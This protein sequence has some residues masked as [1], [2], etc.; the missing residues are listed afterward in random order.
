RSSARVRAAAV[1]RRLG[2]TDEARA[3]LQAVLDDA[4]A[5]SVAGARDA[6]SDALRA[7]GDPGPAP[8]PE[9]L[10]ALRGRRR[11]LDEEVLGLRRRLDEALRTSA[12]VGPLRASLL[13]REGDL[14][15]LQ[16]RIR[17][18]ERAARGGFGALTEREREDRRREDAAAA[19]TL[20]AEWMRYG[21]ESY[22]AGRFEDARRFL[23][24][25]VDLDPGNASARD[26]LARLSAPLDGEPLVA[27]ILEV[28][29]LAQEMDAG[30]IR[31]EAAIHVEEARRLLDAGDA[32]GAMERADAALAQAD[33]RPDLVPRL[34]GARAEAA[35]LFDEAAAR[36]GS[37]R[38][39]PASPAASPGEDPDLQGAVRALLERAGS[40]AEAG[41]A[42]LRV[43]PLAPILRAQGESLPPSPEGGVPLRGFA[44]SAEVPPPGPL[45]QAAFRGAVEPAAWR[46]PG[47]VLDCVGS[48]LVV[49]AGPKALEAAARAIASLESPPT[50]SL[51]VRVSAIPAD[52][53]RVVEVLA[54]A[55]RTL[56]PIARGAGAVAVLDAAAA[57]SVLEALG[58]SAAASADA[59]FR[60]PERRGFRLD[61]LRGHGGP[62]SAAGLGVRGLAWAAAD[63]AVVAGI[64]LSS[65]FPG[66][67]GA[68]EAIGA[69]ALARQEAS[70]GASLSPGGALLF[71]GLADPLGAEAGHI[72]VLVR[73]GDDPRAVAA[74]S[75]PPDAVLPLGDLASRNPDAPGPLSPPDADPRALR[76]EAIRDW[77]G[78]RG[79]VGTEFRVEGTAV[80]VAGPATAAGL[81]ESDLTRLRE[82]A[83]G[84]RVEVRAYALD[85]RSEAS[86]LQGLPLRV[87]GPTASARFVVLRGDERRRNLFLLEG[88]G[89]RI[90]LS[91]GAV[92]VD[93]GRR[94]AFARTEGEGG[95]AAGLEV[96]VRVWPPDVPHARSLWVDLA[97]AVPGGKAPD[98]EPPIRESLPA[99]C[100]LLVVGI[101]N[102]FPDAGT[103]ARVAIWVEAK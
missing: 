2:R 27:K 35:R 28:L 57:A 70:A 58:G 22:A 15:A 97:R 67:R 4:D 59:S 62:D 30:R 29:A 53:T 52:P 19:R 43:F 25:A 82:A 89:G 38:R 55:G 80:R 101:P 88:I 37:P 5:G 40:A 48:V 83:E 77:L 50:R 65:A 3:T 94:V 102:P 8:E 36:A 90:A 64:T 93:P 13:E 10:R 72:V 103:R 12:D 79:A 99:E 41:G 85:G 86:L 56:E 73:L 54:K 61:A 75:A 68:A 78:R 71:A 17:D 66:P 1:L 49:R 45:L 96:G 6:A 60:V 81:A 74:A 69:P 51:S 76:A 14:R 63:G 21:R 42:G 26:L 18:A 84:A 7:L 20:S 39:A 32:V 95:G 87:A 23:R 47:A 11:A 31:A 33:A 24:D 91:G 9:E 92:L 44:L 100:A 46:A 16:E 34:D 98:R